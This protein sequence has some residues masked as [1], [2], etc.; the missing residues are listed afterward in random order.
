MNIVLIRHG[1]TEGNRHKRYIGR[2]D[3]SLCEE[4][5][6][7]AKTVLIPEAFRNCSTVYAS[8][9]KR[10]I[11]TAKLLFSTAQIA[12]VEDFRECDFGD[13]ENKNHLE[14]TCNPDYQKWIDS[15][16]RLPF[17]NGEDREVFVGRCCKAFEN[18]VRSLRED[19][20]IVVAHGGTIMA[21]MEKFAS[22]QK[23]F[24]EWNV[25]NC[26]GYFCEADIGGKI[27]LKLKQKLEI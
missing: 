13:F 9:M 22:P 11:E 3:Q 4:G 8:P 18:L 20:L 12:V 6:I 27:T 24:Y 26:G 14:L 2:T 17:P 19:A 7:A 5:I 23:P 21:I 16:S 1:M 10:C 15:N 25:G